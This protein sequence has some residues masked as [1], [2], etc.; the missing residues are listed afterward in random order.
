M[1]PIRIC[2]LVGCLSLPVSA[3]A[4]KFQYKFTTG[5]VFR[6]SA[7]LA[8]ASMMGPG[9]G[10]MMKM[11]FR[12][13]M[14]QVQ[15][16]RSV[17]GGVATLEI[18]ETPVSGQTIAMGRTEPYK[19]TPSKSQ[20]RLTLR[21]RVV[22]R[23]ELGTREP[24]A[25]SG[26]LDPTD[27]LY[28]LDFPDRDLKPG[29]TWSDTINSG[30]GARAQKVQLQGKFVGWTSFRGRRCAEIATTI[31]MAAA[32]GEESSSASGS[33]GKVSG[34]I[35]TYFDPAAGAELYSKGSL[36][37]TGHMDMSAV[38]PDAG[39]FASV[40]KINFVQSLDAGAARKR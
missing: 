15:R 6:T 3:R 17:S 39:D 21:G 1:S 13:K 38:S 37:I 2:L 18:T 4:E 27:A 30:S 10:P 29:D 36:V 23:K 40:S 7:N 32:A 9:T 14:V 12:V 28:G 20:V 16:V 26:E 33:P 19:K 8:G 22:G 25:P 24:E 5:Q 35:T 11:Q 31:S 34:T